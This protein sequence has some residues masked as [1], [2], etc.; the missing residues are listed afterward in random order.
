MDGVLLI[1]ISIRI[2]QMLNNQ[3][4]EALSIPVSVIELI[5]SHFQVLLLPHDFVGWLYRRRTCIDRPSLF[6]YVMHDQ[7]GCPH[8]FESGSILR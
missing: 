5:C 8:M 3:L 7:F 2:F 4:V 6:L 1:I